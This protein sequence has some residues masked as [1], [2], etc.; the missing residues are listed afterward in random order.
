MGV[1]ERGRVVRVLRERLSKLEDRRIKA[2]LL[3]GSVARGE[4]RGDSDVD[5]LVLHEGLGIEDPVAR[6]RYVYELV[7][8]AV[9]WEFE[10]L[11][12][13]EMELGDF[14]RPKTITPLLLDIYWDAV[15]VLDRTG[16]LEEFLSRVR[17]RIAESGLVRR[18]EGRGYCWVLP[19]PLRRVEIL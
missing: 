11:T 17:R 12:V 18:R 9:G 5:L 4:A 2:V 14:L 13:L 16:S 15:V 1:L 19:V 3:F 7:W 10:A 6:R 8:R